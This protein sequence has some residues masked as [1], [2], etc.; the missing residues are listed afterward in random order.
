MSI[1]AVDEAPLNKFHRKLTWACAG[2]PFLDG[3]LL[4]II[5]VA[6]IGMSNELNLSTGDESLIGAAA[7]V[8]IFVGG[9]FFGPVTDRL[10]REAMYTIDLAVLVGGS[11]LSVFATETWQFVVLRF[12]LGMAIGADYPIATSLLAE[13]V[14]NK[15]RGR[16]LGILILAWYV[17]A[18]AAYVV[19]YVMAEI[20]G[21]GS[22]RW[23]L[24]SGAV[25]SAL[26]LLM[27]IGTPESPLWLV[28]KGR[29]ADAQ[30]AIRKALDRTVPVEELLAASAAEQSVEQSGFR[31]LFQGTYLRRTLFCGL[32]Y[33]CQI[34][35]M[36]ALYTFGPS[37]LGSFGLGEGNESNLG[38]ALISVVFVLGC[39]PAL[40]LVDR[41]GR[42]PVIVW[43]F[44]LM[45]VPLAVLGGGN[46]LP[47]AVVI[48]CFCAYALLSGGPTVLEWTY[49]NELFPTGIRA[50]AGGVATSISRIGAA[51]G[52]YLLPISL[53]RL[54][55]GTTMLIGAGI[56]AV[57]WL[58]SF[59]WAEETR[60]RTL[61]ETSAVPG[62]APPAAADE[63]RRDSL[64]ES[65]L[66]RS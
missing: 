27:R 15:H 38:S 43:S 54:G 16:L 58:V 30:K 18:A 40:R 9:L 39:I 12:V 5:G 34:T 61:A 53:D 64:R 23:M 33:M 10:G 2:G 42:R 13:W 66:G 62:S 8:G 19:G 60:G 36:F 59:A 25:L 65:G 28:N 32:F 14:P 44:A 46:A 4:S 47:I 50:T 20:A 56:T 57:G 31:D 35:P 17:G 21:N 24:A 48:V 37:V 11:L 45:V 63:G 41:V 29:T 51:A 26:I 1:R 49:P 22:W 3:Y 6:L 55:I 52:T 7:L